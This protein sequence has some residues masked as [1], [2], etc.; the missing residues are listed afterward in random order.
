VCVCVCVCVCVILLCVYLCLSVCISVYHK[1][2][3]MHVI[4]FYVVCVRACVMYTV[5]IKCNVSL[6]C[7]SQFAHD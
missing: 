6:A 2:I 1:L 3:H 4:S 5:P 7:M